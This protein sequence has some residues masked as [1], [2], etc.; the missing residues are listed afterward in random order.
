VILF[1]L[2]T[3][4]NYI[5]ENRSWHTY[6]YALGFLWKNRC[7]NGASI[8]NA[9]NEALWV[10]ES[11]SWRIFQVR[12]FCQIRGLLHYPLCVCAFLTLCSPTTC[13]LAIGAGKPSSGDVQPP[14]SVELRARLVPGLV[15]L[16]RRPRGG[17]ADLQWVDG[18]PVAICA[19]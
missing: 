11:P 9:L 12:V 16:S 13:L 14:R 7:D 2:F 5:N 10:H 4:V 3:Y 18:V 15:R 1:L 8:N 17:L 6:S 19:G